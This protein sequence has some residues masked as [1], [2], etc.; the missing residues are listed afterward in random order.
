[1]K[2]ILSIAYLI[3][4]SFR[5]GVFPLKWKISP[6][7]PIFKG[8]ISTNCNNYR[9]VAYQKRSSCNIALIRLVDE[10]K[11]SIDIKQ[12]AVAAFLDLRKAFEVINHNLLL[13]KLES[14]GLMA[15]R[16]IGLKATLIIVHNM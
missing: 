14:V 11:W 16:F 10:C 7:S 8:G 6:V 1:M 4:E 2:T 15:L 12:I 5:Q 9:P 13:K 3:N